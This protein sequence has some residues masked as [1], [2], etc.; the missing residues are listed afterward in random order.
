MFVNTYFTFFFLQNLKNVT[1]YVFCFV[2]Y[3]FSNNAYA[4]I[5]RRITT[6]FG[7]VTHEGGGA[8]RDQAH[9]I[10]THPHFCGS[11]KLMPAPFGI[12]R[13]NSAS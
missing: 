13:P 6:K 11:L 12:E 3:V 2:A 10:P 7:A 8:F 9:P 1:F 5:L 4:H